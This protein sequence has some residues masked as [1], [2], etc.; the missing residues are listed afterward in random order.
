MGFQQGLSGL[1]AAARNLDVIGNNVANANT[2]GFKAAQR[3]VRRRLRELA[4]RRRRQRSAGIGVSVTAIQQNFVQGNVSTTSNPL[5]I[6]IN[7]NGFFRMDTKRHGAATRATASS[8]ST[9]TASSSTR[10]ARRLTGYGVD[11]AGT[12]LIS[13]PGPLQ[14]S[15]AAPAGDDD[16][17]TKIGLNLDS[18]DPG[19]SPARSTSPIRRP[20]TRRRR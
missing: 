19:R 17:A 18:R 4:G 20:T 11:A 12:I 2:V 7:G 9:R 3:R 6:A 1:I 16:A 8:T 15:M 5:D 14:V 10:P 13:A